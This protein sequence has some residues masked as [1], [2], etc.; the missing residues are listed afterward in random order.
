MSTKQRRTTLALAMVAALVIAAC[1]K[2]APPQAA[3][4]V[5]P[6][7]AADAD[8]LCCAGLGGPVDRVDG[9]IR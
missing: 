8:T 2:S 6:S 1:G 3:D 7:T 9:S 4:S 5:T